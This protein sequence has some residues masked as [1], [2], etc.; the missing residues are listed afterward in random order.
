M[1]ASRVSP[2]ATPVMSRR[3]KGLG[4]TW[5]KG[6]AGCS[7]AAVTTQAEIINNASS[8][9][10]IR[11]SVQWVFSASA[12][13]RRVCLAGIDSPTNGDATIAASAEFAMNLSVMRDGIQSSEGSDQNTQN[14]LLGGGLKRYRRYLRPKLTKDI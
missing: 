9:D 4:R 1:S 11:Y 5:R 10:S 6:D 8:A 12:T 2:M 3:V 13:D 14:D 7:R